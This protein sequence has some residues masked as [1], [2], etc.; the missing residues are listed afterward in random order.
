VIE[1]KGTAPTSASVPLETGAGIGVTAG[2]DVGPIASTPDPASAPT[3]VD[4]GVSAAPLAVGALVPSTGAEQKASVAA[5]VVRSDPKARYEDVLACVANVEKRLGELTAISAGIRDNKPEP[6]EPA[7]LTSEGP[8]V[9]RRRPSEFR[10]DQNGRDSS[11]GSA[12]KKLF[13]VDD[14]PRLRREGPAINMRTGMV[15][16]RCAAGAAILVAASALFLIADDPSVATV[17]QALT[18]SMLFLAIIF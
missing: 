8:P 1:E 4:V 2:A 6:I 12:S 14:G 3:H 16:A 13:V 5:D 10:R 11:G 17:L 15:W 9:P 7:P 18:G